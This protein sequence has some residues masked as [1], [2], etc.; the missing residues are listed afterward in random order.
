M[1]SHEGGPKAAALPTLLCPGRD[2]VE[3]GV[4]AVVESYVDKHLGR[5]VEVRVATDAVA[6]EPEANPLR[7]L[8]AV[9]PRRCP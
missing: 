7:R 1:D 3:K 8:V 4:V 2:L 5:V 6:I 9:Q